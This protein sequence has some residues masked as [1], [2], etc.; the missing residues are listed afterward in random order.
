M[1]PRFYLVGE[2]EE[3]WKLQMLRRILKH[4]GGKV[5]LCEM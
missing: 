4:G 2:Q 5:G 1:E 3:G